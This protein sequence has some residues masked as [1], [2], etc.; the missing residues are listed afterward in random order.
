[1]V[2]HLDVLLQTFLAK[3]HVFTQFLISLYRALNDYKHSVALVSL[4]VDKLPFLKV[5]KLHAPHQGLNRVSIVKLK[6][7]NLSLK[8]HL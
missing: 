7:L 2:S 5:I 8:V 6:E 4:A 3:H 1:V